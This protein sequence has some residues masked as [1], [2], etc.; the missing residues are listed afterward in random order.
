[1]SLVLE[2]IHL[3]SRCDNPLLT[4]LILTLRLMGL[5]ISQSLKP[6]LILE[7]LKV[8]VLRLLSI[9]KCH[10]S[11]LPL[12]LDPLFFPCWTRTKTRM[13]NLFG[14]NLLCPRATP[15][16]MSIIHTLLSTPKWS[17]SQALEDQF[18]SHFGFSLLNHELPCSDNALKWDKVCKT[19]GDKVHQVKDKN[20]PCIR[21]F[22]SH[23]IQNH[24][25]IEIL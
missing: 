14:S 6:P 25:N 18:Y 22:V 9:L 4:C 15:F 21:T 10:L 20:W 5:R 13:G 7:I 19:L 12:T 1:M 3:I 11:K 8:L 17:Y 16:L 2:M 24:T 23:F